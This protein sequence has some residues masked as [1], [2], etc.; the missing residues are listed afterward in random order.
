[1]KLSV[2]REFLDSVFEWRN[3]NRYKL[4][5]IRGGFCAGLPRVC[6]STDECNQYEKLHQYLIHSSYESSAAVIAR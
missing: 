3:G 6:K 2:E 1:M 4:S 5:G